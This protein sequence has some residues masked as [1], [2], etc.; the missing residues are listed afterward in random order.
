MDFTS[1]ALQLLGGLAG[2]NAAGKALPNLDLGALGNSITGAAG[3]IAGGQLLQALIPALSG[4]GGGDIGA[5]AGQLFGGGVTGAI[6]TAL[7][8][9]VMQT[10][11]GPRKA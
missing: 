3:G 9:L 1:L 10:M 5:L 8:G 4:A 2:G 11:G 7:V 6:V